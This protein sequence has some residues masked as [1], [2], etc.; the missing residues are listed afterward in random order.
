MPWASL[1][2]VSTLR[3]VRSVLLGAMLLQWQMLASDIKKCNHK[4]G[5]ALHK[6]KNLT[7]LVFISDKNGSMSEL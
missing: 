2:W 7:E 1:R 5:K 6:K 4:S 3:Q